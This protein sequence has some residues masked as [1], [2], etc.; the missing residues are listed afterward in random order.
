MATELTVSNNYRLNPTRS[1]HRVA[2]DGRIDIV[3][4]YQ[5]IIADVRAKFALGHASLCLRHSECRRDHGFTRSTLP[6]YFRAALIVN[7]ARMFDSA[8]GFEGPA[9]ARAL[10]QTPGF[11]GHGRRL[12]L[13]AWGRSLARPLPGGPLPLQILPGLADSPSHAH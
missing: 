6:L 13:R 7:S 8:A 4:S 9:A 2:V 1:E 11:S 10:P 12:A 5:I 3:A